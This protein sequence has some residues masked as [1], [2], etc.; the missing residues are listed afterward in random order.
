MVENRPRTGCGTVVWTRYQPMHRTPVGRRELLALTAAT[1][2]AAVGRDVRRARRVARLDPPTAQIDV[3]VEPPLCS[4]ERS[5]RAMQDS[6]GSSRAARPRNAKERPHLGAQVGSADPIRLA[7]L[8]DSSIAGVGADLV[9]DCL[10]VQIAARVAGDTGR[11][12]RVRGYG[13]SG[14][15]TADIAQ[16][17]RALDPADPPDA[18]VV[19]VGAND[20]AHGTPPAAYRRAVSAVY[21]EIA[22]RLSTPVVVCSLPEFRAVTVVGGPLRQLAIGYGRLLGVLQ[23]RALVG[24][25]GVRWVDARRAA[26]PAFLHHPHAMSADGYHPSG[27]GYALLADALGPAVV[28]A[29]DDP[30]GPG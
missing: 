23:R 21:R 1:V 8:G 3:R 6:A 7:A 10:A 24:I 15:R 16:Q 9:A 30:S 5:D 22:Q 26:G 2:G 19:V 20:V 13:A 28:A 18:I 4:A 11:P 27:F 25:P 29:L 17:A 12:V 14:A